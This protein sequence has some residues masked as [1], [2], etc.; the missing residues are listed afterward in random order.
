MPIKEKSIPDKIEVKNI[1]HSF[2]NEE[3]NEIGANLA[4][5]IGGLR[6]TE[7]EFDQVK[8][9]FKARITEADAR[10]DKLSTDL[11]NGFEMRN[12]RCIVVFYPAER[13]KRYSLEGGDMTVVLEEEMTKDDF[14]AELLQAESAFDCREEIT[15]FKPQNNDEGLLVVGRLASKWFS[16]LRVRIGKLELTE[17]LDSEQRSFKQRPDAVAHA[18]KRVNAWAKENL[19]DLADGFKAS[20]DAVQEAHKEREE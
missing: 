17:R 2:T 5:T 15:L 10:I 9:S 8:A 16:A 20:F 13:K 11:V 1:K 7:A 12:K 4:R 19:K 14:Q 6:G 18:V 3:R